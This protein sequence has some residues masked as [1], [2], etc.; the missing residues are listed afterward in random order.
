MVVS[1]ARYIRIANGP[2][3]INFGEVRAFSKGAVLIPPVSIEMSSITGSVWQTSTQPT[4]VYVQG[5]ACASNG[6]C[7]EYTLT[8][9]SAVWTQASETGNAIHFNGEDWCISAATEDD[10]VYKKSGASVSGLYLQSNDISKT[11]RVKIISPE[12]IALATGRCIDGVL[13]Y[14]ED[15]A[16]AENCHSDASDEDTWLRIDYGESVV[17][18]HIVI[19]NREGYE[20]RAVGAQIMTSNDP[21]GDEL[22][23]SS[24]IE[25]QQ[26][27]H[28]VSTSP[29]FNQVDVEMMQYDIS[30]SGMSSV[31]DSQSRTYD[32]ESPGRNATRVPFDGSL[33]FDQV[34]PGSRF[35]LRVYPV[36]AHAG[37]IVDQVYTRVGDF[38]VQ[39]KC[40]CNTGTFPDLNW[41]SDETGTP[42]HFVVSQD[43][44]QVYFQW[45][46]QSR[47]ESAYSISRKFGDVLPIAIGPDYVHSNSGLEECGEAIETGAATDALALAGNVQPFGKVG[48]QLRYFVR[49]T[50]EIGVGAKG[51]ASASASASLVVQWESVVHGTVLSEAG[52]VPIEGV[53]IEWVV[54]DDDMAPTSVASVAGSGV[55]SELDGS[56]VVHL[57]DAYGH[58]EGRLTH[59]H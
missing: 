49:A 16:S 55:Y 47:C 26:L 7:G 30:Q 28:N 8:Q 59:T 17:I 50:S 39:T 35:F 22:V 54:L 38:A 46:D 53:K 3:I 14:P 27:V 11:L 56:F 34:N 20:N 23:W 1:A 58:L 41:A 51:Y 5:P 48:S 18:D 43:H 12:Q 2:R 32:I 52:S 19:N 13:E 44:G 24:K 33:R 42:H 37:R 21:D 29:P 15:V 40:G 45:V 4:T 31:R 25:S 6:Y 57:I 36:D 9:S 10:C